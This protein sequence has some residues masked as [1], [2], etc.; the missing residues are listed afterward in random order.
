MNL[1]FRKA[2]IDDLFEIQTLY[3]NVV[4]HMQSSGIDQWDE[5]YPTKDDFIQDIARGEMTLCLSDGKVAAAFTV[6]TCA[7]EE[8]FH[9]DWQYPDA[10]W[11]VVHR[12][13]VSPHLQHSGIATQVMEYVE[14]TALSEG[15]EAIHLDTFSGNPK[16]LALYH[17][18]GFADVGEAYWR[19]GRFIIMEKKL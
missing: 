17:K 1:T 6:N 7:D 10:K 11:C 4:A 8:Y 9:N 19:K 18:L 12:L 5:V 14:K 15:F 3:K 2:T 16:A 13:C